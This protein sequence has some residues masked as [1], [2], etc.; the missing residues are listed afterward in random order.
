MRDLEGL[1][2][3]VLHTEKVF[4]RCD[5]LSWPQSQAPGVLPPC[6]LAFSSL[7]EQNDLNLSCLEREWSVT[8]CTYFKLNR[9]TCYR[10]S[11]EKCLS[12]TPFPNTTPFSPIARSLSNGQIP[13]VEIM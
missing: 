1:P 5:V 13:G 6:R 12:Y 2:S 4:K 8:T 11:K 9:F 7:K 10:K 3:V